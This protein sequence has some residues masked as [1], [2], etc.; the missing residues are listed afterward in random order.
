MDESLKPFYE[1]F[2]TL[3]NKL[4]KIEPLYIY[5]APPKM[6]YKEFFEIL[7]DPNLAERIKEKFRNE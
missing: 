6:T 1:L 5:T 4:G 2:S 7:T 3:R